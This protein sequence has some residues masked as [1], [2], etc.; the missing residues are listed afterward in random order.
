MTT[1]QLTN[2]KIPIKVNEESCLLVE[3]AI[4]WINSNTS[5]HYDLDNLPESLPSNVKLFISKYCELIGLRPGI[6]SESISGLSQSFDSTDK[7]LLLRQYAKAI[8]GDSVMSDV[9][10]FSAKKRW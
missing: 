7:G 10:F 6:S 8:L 4:E 1:E 2:Y 9:T 5:L 3:S